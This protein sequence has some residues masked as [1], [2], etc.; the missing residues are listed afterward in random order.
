MSGQSLVYPSASGSALHRRFGKVFRRGRCPSSYGGAH[1]WGWLRGWLCAHLANP[2]GLMGPSEDWCCAEACPRL[3]SEKWSKAMIDNTW[4]P[5][6]KR[7]PR[8][9]VCSKCGSEF[10][11]LPPV[12]ERPRCPVRMCHS[13]NVRMTPNSLHKKSRRTS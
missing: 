4:Q 9:C 1:Q 6:Q 8:K 5:G 13:R 12:L 3:R 2:R 7:K 11:A 10:W